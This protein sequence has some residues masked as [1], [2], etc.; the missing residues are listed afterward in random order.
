MPLRQT[1]ACTKRVRKPTS[2]GTAYVRA[3]SPA[4]ARSEMNSFFSK[5]R[6]VGSRSD[7]NSSRR[8]CNGDHWEGAGVT[9]RTGGDDD[10]RSLQGMPRSISTMV[11]IETQ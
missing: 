9:A 1:T 8:S 11:H 7:F 2:Q 4:A 6:L 5:V 3:I 10:R